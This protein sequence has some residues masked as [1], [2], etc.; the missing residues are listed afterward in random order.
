MKWSP[1]NKSYWTNLTQVQMKLMLEA[2]LMWLKVR[3]SKKCL[4]WKSKS[5]YP[6]VFFLKLK[7]FKTFGVTPN[8]KIITSVSKKS[9][10]T[11]VLY[12]YCSL[13]RLTILNLLT[14]GWKVEIKNLE[15]KDE[16]RQLL[17]Y[18]SLIRACNKVLYQ[19]VYI[20]KKFVF[21][22]KN[23]GI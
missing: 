20:G 2:L 12:H 3:I 15:E 8:L 18:V 5:L 23:L 9:G 11:I 13:S 1:K 14:L 7:L 17:Y 4:F 10:Q 16:Q 19:L 6:S 22:K 21:L